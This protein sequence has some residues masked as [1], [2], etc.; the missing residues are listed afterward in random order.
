MHQV[1]DEVEKLAMERGV[2]VT[3]SE[4]V[5]IIPIEPILMAGKHYLKKQGRCTA[6]PD[7]D[8]IHVAKTTLGLSDVQPF[9]VEDKIIEYRLQKG[10]KNNS[11]GAQPIKVFLDNLSS[12]SPAPGGGSV[13]ALCGSLASALVSMVGNLTVGKKGMEASYQ[14]CNE[15]AEQAQKLKI[16][17]LNQI[18]ADTNAFNVYMDA[19]K[20]PKTDATKDEKVI[21]AQ[22]GATLVPFTVLERSVEIYT[23]AKEIIE[24]GNPM[25]L[26]DGG[27]AGLCANSCGWGAYYNVLINLNGMKKGKKW[28]SEMRKKADELIAKHDE[29]AK[30]VKDLTISKLT[31][32]KEKKAAEKKD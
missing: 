25:A 29:G 11:L 30:M 3:G 18:D 27:C 31:E 32:K 13:A 10:K 2:R 14:R 4:I 23:I 7:S 6:C 21:E 16:W 9:N 19:I 26:S 5:G 17:F 12:E 28:V 15:I 20:L 8:L 22:K 24:I 1:F